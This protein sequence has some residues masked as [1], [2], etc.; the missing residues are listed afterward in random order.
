LCHKTFKQKFF[1]Q[2]EILSNLRNLQAEIIKQFS[3]MS[4]HFDIKKDLR[5]QQGVEIGNEQGIEIGISQ[6]NKD[7]VLS[8]LAN[9]DFD[10]EKIAQIVGVSVEFV[11]N[12]KKS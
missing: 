8:L 11:Q 12:L 2:L 9:T 5:F 4:I 1:L 6:K 7:F 10:N 3:T